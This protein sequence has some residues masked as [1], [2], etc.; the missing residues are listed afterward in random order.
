V[1]STTSGGAVCWGNNQFGQLGTGDKVNRLVGTRVKN[2][3][4]F[5][6]MAAGE[7]FS[8]GLA[9]AGVLYCWG[10]NSKG[11]L[12][13]GTTIGSTLP[14]R[15]SGN[16]FIK[17]LAL[18]RN[19]ACGV[20]SDDLAYCWGNNASG[21]LGTGDRINRSV[22]TR[23]VPAYIIDAIAAGGAHVCATTG[24]GA[25]FGTPAPFRPAAIPPAP[26]VRPARALSRRCSPPRS[27]DR[28]AGGSLA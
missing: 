20:A 16:L 4:G 18:G 21:Q 6:G 27:S 7:Y 17:K 28:S 11:Q 22:P 3:P 9:A 15:V 5:I 10:D 23:V 19:F 8:C 14:V 24:G 25:A 2:D 26:A 1:R 12:G 13:N